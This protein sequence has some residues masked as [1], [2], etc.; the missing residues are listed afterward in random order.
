MGL[1]KN[2]GLFIAA[3]T[4]AGFAMSS[5]AGA[6]VVVNAGS[7]FTLTA[8]GAAGLPTTAT[9]VLSTPALDIALSS[10]G[11]TAYASGLI[12]NGGY[13]QHQ[14]AHLNDGTY[15]NSNSWIG[16]NNVNVYDPTGTTV[17][18]QSFAG[19]ALPTTVS[20][21]GY[22]LT[23][24]AFGR[25]QTGTF[26]DRDSGTY[27]IEYTTVANPSASTV[28]SAYSIL[29]TVTIDGGGANPGDALRQLFTLTT[30][31]DMTGLRIVVPAGAGTNPVGD[32][33]YPTFG[34]ANDIDEI[35]MVGTVALPEPASLSLIGLGA[36]SLLARRR[37]A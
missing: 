20:G 30:P 32:A 1:S 6:S 8:T 4:A 21:N 13:P 15:G 5:I 28:D 24:F 7:D 33:T 34:S 18:G 36:V 31:V 37:R 11:S 35:E 19:I 3:A 9:P 14:I 23:Q 12:A 25:D 10:N 27:Y 2:S 17:I 26:Q 16:G 22:A 29:G